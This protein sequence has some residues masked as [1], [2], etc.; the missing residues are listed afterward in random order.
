MKQPG[1]N[2]NVILQPSDVAEMLGLGGEEPSGEG[3]PEDEGE[4][5]EHGPGCDCPDCKKKGGMGKMKMGK[6]MMD[7]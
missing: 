5:E 2:I 3:E 6:M 4:G 7:D 1:V